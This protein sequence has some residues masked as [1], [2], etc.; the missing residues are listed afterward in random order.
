MIC[1]YLGRGVVEKLEVVNKKWVRVRLQ[2]GSSADAS[3]RF[4]YM[5]L[6]GYMPCITKVMISSLLPMQTTLWFN[7][8]SVD[9]FERNLESVQLEM[10]TE[11]QNFLPVIY[12]TELEA[13]S[14]SGILP[15]LLIIGVYF[16][17]F[18]FLYCCA[19]LTSQANPLIH[20][21]SF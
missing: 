11:P 13:A 4:G 19:S 18:M 20:V 14:I 7:I 16:C 6:L 12:K 3:V 8:G 10:N 9:S 2:P 21:L 15:T 1:S 17:V 5:L